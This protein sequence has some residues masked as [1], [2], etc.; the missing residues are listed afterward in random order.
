MALSRAALFIVFP[1][2]GPATGLAQDITNALPVVAVAAEHR[3]LSE[4]IFGEGTARAVRREFLLFET[5]GKVEFIWQ[6]TDSAPLKEGDKVTGPAGAEPG[7]LLARL[8]QRLHIAER[9]KSTAQLDQARQQL[10]SAE[11]QIRAAQAEFDAAGS[12]LKRA[13]A[14]VKKGI[15]TQARLDETKARFRGSRAQVAS[16]KAQADAARSDVIGAQARLR[17]A[18]LALDQTEIRAPFDGTV[19]YINVRRGDLV[20]RSNVDTST[21]TRANKTVPI[22]LID[23]LA[24]EITLQLPVFDGLRARVGQRAW[25]VTGR[26]L[27]A[28]QRDGYKV[29]DL[30]KSFISARVFS[31]SPSISPG[32]RSVR[33][34]VRTDGEV[35]TLADGSF[36][37]I[38]IEVAERDMT[39]VVP[40]NSVILRGDQAHAFVVDESTARVE[41]RV[42]KIGLWGI[43]GV[44]IIDGLK[45]G[46]FIVTKGRGRLADG[47]SVH[48]V[49]REGSAK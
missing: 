4:Y 31:V 44:E 2:L 16:N 25:I 34:K 17:Q 20:S 28:I 11:A 35:R 5:D 46:E 8:D 19:A 18:E 6:R 48:V 29:A 43:D 40:Y 10:A 15:A 42:L 21:E 7:Q 26:S 30:T 9:D 37:S 3:Q 24:Y 38:W 33:V 41:K 22:V 36:A 13:E 23:D 32:N 27:A 1:L 45:P 39:V 47:Q 14:L 49:S 12:D